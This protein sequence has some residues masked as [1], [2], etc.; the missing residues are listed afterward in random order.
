MAICVLGD[1]VLLGLASQSKQLGGH[2]AA[3]FF[4]YNGASV[5]QCFQMKY[6]E[7][8]GFCEPSGAAV[9]DTDGIKTRKEEEK[10]EKMHVGMIG[11]T[12][13]ME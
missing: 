5:L 6:V 4:K 11:Q 1:V 7:G 12:T 2:F 9:E 10:K 3:V 8:F 13:N